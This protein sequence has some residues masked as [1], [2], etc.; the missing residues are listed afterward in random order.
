MNFRLL[1]FFF[2]AHRLSIYV[3][4]YNSTRKKKRFI[5]KGD[6]GETLSKIFIIVK[7]KIKSFLMFIPINIIVKN[8]NLI[9]TYCSR[10]F[11]LL[12]R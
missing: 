3:S 9:H 7:I 1:T 6:Y 2:D 8:E 5:S 11:V 10:D 12:Q 4:R